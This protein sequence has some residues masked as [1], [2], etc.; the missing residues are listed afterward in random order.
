M[1]KDPK[2]DDEEDDVV[3]YDDFGDSFIGGDDDSSSS[4]TSFSNVLQ[5]RIKEQRSLIMA[6]DAK[7]AKNW[8]DGNWSV[9][10][11]ALDKSNPIQDAY[12]K[13]KGEGRDIQH[14]EEEEEEE[15]GEDRVCFSPDKNFP[16]DQTNTDTPKSIHIS[17]I[18]LDLERLDDA[19][20]EDFYDVL[21]IVGRT[22]GSACVVKLGTEYLA[23]FSAVPTISLNNQDDDDDANTIGGG[24]V[25]EDVVEGSDSATI[26]FSSKLVRSSPDDGTDEPIKSNANPNSAEQNDGLPPPPTRFEIMHQFQA[27]ESGPITAILY[28]GASV[29]T[30]GGIDG[31]ITHW[32]LPTDEH[33]NT[34][35]AM[36]IKPLPSMRNAHSDSILAIKTLSSSSSKHHD[37]LLTVSGR[38]ATFAVWD[39]DAT[40]HDLIHKVSLQHHLNDDSISILSAEVNEEEGYVFLGLSSGR[41]LGY[42]LKEVLSSASDGRDAIPSCNFAAHQDGGDVTA[43]CCAGD[44]SMSLQRSAADTTDAA[45]STTTTTGQK[46][47]ILIT[48]GSDGKMKQWEIFPR[49]ASPP[50]N[51]ETTQPIKLEHWPRLPTQRMKRR[52]HTFPIHHSGPIKAISSLPSDPT[53]LLS[54]ATDGRIHVWNPM[55]GEKMYTMEGFTSDIS[56]LCL[57]RAVLVTDGMDD[58]VCLHDF[59][60]DD[61]H[62]EEHFDPF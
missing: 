27:S 57:D 14:E 38:D 4:S 9:R 43:L 41:V 17:K 47:I 19:N 8:R 23:T 24:S 62:V 34:K 54:C 26:R 60:V 59:M 1:T 35:D 36:M 15:E 29:Y 50:T 25:E 5:N 11:F 13:I 3:Y 21:L 33:S 10:G 42:T 31:V 49:N 58:L 20:I 61:M 39:R 22:D 55:S 45:I 28:E 6:R 16:S 52:A 32:E 30:S 48:G 37:I 12:A 56:S 46:S 40:S 51:D 2:G 44:G 7:L 18:A 53:K